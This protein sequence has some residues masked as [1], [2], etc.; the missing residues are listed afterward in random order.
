MRKMVISFILCMA[1]VFMFLPATARAAEFSNQEFSLELNKKYSSYYLTFDDHNYEAYSVQ[2]LD[3]T[4]VLPEGLDWRW[5]ATG[6]Y[7]AGTPTKSGEYS[8]AFKIVRGDDNSE[9]IHRVFI[10]VGEGETSSEEMILYTT[11]DYSREWLTFDDHNSEAI[12]V[13]IS[14]GELPEGLNWY[15]NA[16]G[17]YLKGSPTEP[18]VYC[19]TFR[20]VRG[21]DGSVV[22]HSVTINVKEPEHSSEEIPLS[23]LQPIGRRFL[24]FDDHNYE[25]KSVKLINGSLPEG[26]DWSCNAEGICLTGTPTES[27]SYYP[28]FRIVRGDDDSVLLHSVTIVVYDEE[29]M[30][31]TDVKEGDWYYD[32]IEFNYIYGYMTGKTETTFVPL[33]NI[34]RAQFAVILHRLEGQVQTEYTPVFPD[35]QDNIWYTDAILWASSKKIVTGYSDTGMFGPADNITWEQMAVMMYRYAQYKGYDVSEMADFSPFDDAASVSVYAQEAMG[36]AVGT[37]IITGKY[38]GTMLD[39]QGNALRAECAIIIQRFMNYYYF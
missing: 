31:F 4:G 16:E 1:M 35:V 2:M 39:P 20:V 12:T 33:E 24:L 29:K 23:V 13:D 8:V 19:A 30:P 28:T 3:G 27:G 25:T 37:G 38:A 22:R 21:D 36:W 10:T 9:L 17:I 15:W 7:L 32:A 34:A 11:A 6:I 5:N 14:D 26:M 18:G